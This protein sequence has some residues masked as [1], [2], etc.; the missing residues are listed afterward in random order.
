[1]PTRI[2]QKSVSLISLSIMA[3]VVGCVTGLGAVVLRTLMALLHNA[4]FLREFSFYYD[5]N[6]LT[7]ASPWGPWI[8]LVPVIGGLGTVWLVRTF[9]PEAKGHGVPEVMNAVYYQEGRIRP[10]VVVVKSLASALSIGSGAAV[11][12]EG[13]MIQI[14]SALGSSVGQFGRLCSWQRITLVA[15]GAGAGIAGYLQ[16][17]AGR[18]DVR[19]RADAARGQLPHLPAGGTGDRAPPPISAASSLAWSPPFWCR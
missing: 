15:A 13:P 19:G 6:Q 10:M 8:I 3:I 1:M 7:P 9:A 17:A 5:A 4:L 16:H 11:G 2:S 14:G 18:V 12:R